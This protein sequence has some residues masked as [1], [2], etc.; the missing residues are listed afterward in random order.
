VTGIAS[1]VAAAVLTLQILVTNDAGVSPR[2][3]ASAQET[4]QHLYRLV[5][6]EIVWVDRINRDLPLV[7]ALAPPGGGERIGVGENVMGHAFRTEEP[8]P[9]GR[10]LIFVDRVQRRADLSRTTLPR[11]L[12]AVMAHE[13]GHMLLPD[14]HSRTGLMRGA[15][16]DRDLQ[17][18][19]MVG[20]RFSDGERERIR[21]QLCRRLVTEN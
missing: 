20:L 11:L 21:R 17:L 9:G 13:I 3:L 10:A 19:D 4:V 8:W 5:G 12:G 15:W 7:V 6:I 2:T 14:A 18:I 1:T 16:N